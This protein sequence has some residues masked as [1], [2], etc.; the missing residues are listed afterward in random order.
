MLDKFYSS[1]IGV[2]TMRLAKRV[3]AFVFGVLLSIVALNIITGLV[4][5]GVL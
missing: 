4:R 1:R 2:N 5:M 3:F